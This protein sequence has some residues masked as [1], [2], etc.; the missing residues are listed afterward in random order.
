MPWE[1][2]RDYVG[3]HPNHHLPPRPPDEYLAT[4]RGADSLRTQELIVVTPPP[5]KS[6]LRFAIVGSG[7]SGFYT[8]AA[9]LDNPD[10]DAWV[11]MYEQLATPWGLVR[12]GVAPDHPKIK[13]I[14]AVFA[15]IAARERFRFFGN[16]RVGHDVARE[17]LLERYDAVIYTVGSQGDRALGIPGEELPGSVG[18]VEFV[19]WYNGHPDFTHRRFDFNTDRAVVIGNGNVALDLARIL[20]S[21]S[22]HLAGTDIADHALSALAQSQI[23]E[24]LVLGR[25]GPAQAAFTT[26][27][28]RELPEFT[29]SGVAVDPAQLPAEADDEALPKVAR[30]NLAVLR[31]YASPPQPHGDRHITFRFQRSPLALYGRDR[32]EGVELAV[33]ELVATEDGSV[34][35]RDTG[36]RERVDTNL[37]LRAVGYRGLPLAGLPYDER[38]GVIPNDQGRILGT[39]REYVAGWIKRGPT[40]IIGTNKKDAT[41]TVRRL[42]ADLAD[43]SL[44]TE[45]T[46]NGAGIESWLACRQPRFV[47]EDSWQLID[48]A[49]RAAGELA[50]R[51]RVKLA[52]TSELL[53]IAFPD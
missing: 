50:G 3:D 28:L 5:E 7:P 1:P 41:E 29:A 8:A 46:D 51:P 38:R 48:A 21:P 31:G 17:E 6:P 35:P 37:V 12:A 47:S 42:I 15:K 49:E 40:G 43:G 20:C 30:R 25:R 23:S 33:N 39:T 13:S 4:G 52:T 44:P 53:D 26:P 32:V 9:L 2:A 19:G 36:S 34:R 45:P 24:V 22:E 11:D 16:V 27:E 14:S 10:L 18:A